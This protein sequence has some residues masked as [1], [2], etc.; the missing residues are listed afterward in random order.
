[1]KHFSNKDVDH[2]REEEQVFHCGPNL[3]IQC[4][5]VSFINYFMDKQLLHQFIYYYYFYEL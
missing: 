5:Q 3:M 2:I 4:E 1:M